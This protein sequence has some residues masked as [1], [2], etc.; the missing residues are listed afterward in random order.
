MARLP[1]S[2]RLVRP[3]P[4]TVW[5][6][7]NV[8]G[9]ADPGA[10]EMGTWLSGCGDRFRRTLRRSCEG[11]SSSGTHE[12][13]FFGYRDLLMTSRSLTY[14]GFLHIR[15]H[16]W[17]SQ[18]LLIDPLLITSF[19]LRQNRPRITSPAPQCSDTGE[20]EPCLPWLSARGQDDGLIN[21]LPLRPRN[22]RQGSLV[23]A[24]GH[25]ACD[26]SFA[27]RIGDKNSW[28]HGLQIQLPSIIPSAV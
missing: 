19:R 6:G 7:C 9:P 24:Q 3:A 12:P 26:A 27:L 4:D 5:G 20:F 8:L 14:P 22:S 25:G 10:G 28:C 13:V 16:L 17:T 21:D 11:G 1:A 15:T 23:T 2:A 18:S